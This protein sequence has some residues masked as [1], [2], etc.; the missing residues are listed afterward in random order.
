VRTKIT[1]TAIKP[2][3]LPRFYAGEGDREAVEGAGLAKRFNHKEDSRVPIGPTSHVAIDAV[4][5]EWRGFDHARARAT[6]I[7]HEGWEMRS[8]DGAAPVSLVLI[9]SMGHQIAGGA[10]D[11]L[12][13]Q[14]MKSEPDEVAMALGFFGEERGR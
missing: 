1:R 7:S 8:H 14:A 2:L 11:H 6:I 12:P 3:F 9:Q 13:R 10:D 5:A 4:I